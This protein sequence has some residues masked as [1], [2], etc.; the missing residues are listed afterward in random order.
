MVE[1]TSC[2][3]VVVKMRSD[4]GNGASFFHAVVLLKRAGEA[5]LCKLYRESVT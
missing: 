2:Y 3:E 4:S 1:E 5:P